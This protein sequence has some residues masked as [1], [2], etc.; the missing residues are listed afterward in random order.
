[1]IKINFEDKE[2]KQFDSGISAE[3]VVKETYGRKSGAVAVL[4]E[5]KEYDL[6]HKLLKD[7]KIDLIKADSDEG[8]YILRHS[9]A[10]LLAQAVTELFP[11]AKPT[12]GPPV[13]DGFYYDFYMDPI[14][15]DDLKKIEKKMKEM[16][17]QNISIIREGILKTDIDSLSAFLMSHKPP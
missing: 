16:V 5:E 1:M 6:S 13:D 3:D 9:C 17:K 7:C 10:H 11:K 14:N 8:L 2:A 12:I 4:I 15:D